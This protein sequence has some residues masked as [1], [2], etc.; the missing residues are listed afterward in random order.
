MKTS[1]DPVPKRKLKHLLK[2]FNAIP[3]KTAEIDSTAATENPRT[4][5]KM[6]NNCSNTDNSA[7]HPPSR[8]F[9]CWDNLSVLIPMWGCHPL[10]PRNVPRRAYLMVQMET[11]F[12]LPRTNSEQMEAHVDTATWDET[13][14]SNN[15][16]R[17][18]RP[19]SA[20]AFIKTTNNAFTE[21]GE[22]LKEKPKEILVYAKCM[23]TI[24]LRRSTFTNV[25]ENS[26]PGLD[27]FLLDNAKVYNSRPS[28]KI[29]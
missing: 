3:K 25:G 10:S 12:L 18:I 14:R 24:P 8:H 29:H 11:K 19:I 1:K 20:D 9:I 16:I 15:R 23:S 28:F 13:E 21:R 22:Q 4:A 2:I 5:S 26:V 17:P 27:K 7:L 6:D